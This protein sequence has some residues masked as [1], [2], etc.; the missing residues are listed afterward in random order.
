[1]IEILKEHFHLCQILLEKFKNVNDP[2]IIQR[3]YGVVFGACCKR[4][5]GRGFQALAEHVYREVFDQEKVYPDILLRDY[6]RLIIELFLYENPKYIGEIVREK[7]VPPYSSDPIPEIEDQHYLENDYNGAMFWLMH[8]MRF[9]GM[10]TISRRN[11]VSLKNILESM[12]SVMAAMIDIRLKR[13]K[14][15]AKSINGLQCIICWP[16]FLIIAR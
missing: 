1:M 15:L 4:T 5:D 9:E 12:T 3:L 6:A 7:I 11:S 10:G 16:V 13:L 2:Y 14:E 8:S